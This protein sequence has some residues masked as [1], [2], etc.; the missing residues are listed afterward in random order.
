MV[1]S[2]TQDPYSIVVSLNLDSLRNLKIGHSLRLTE[3]LLEAC[4]LIYLCSDRT[5][6]RLERRNSEVTHMITVLQ[7]RTL[8]VNGRVSQHRTVSGKHIDT[9]TSIP[10]PRRSVGTHLPVLRRDIPDGAGEG[11]YSDSFYYS[12]A[13]GGGSQHGTV[14]GKHIDAE[15]SIPGPLRSAWTH[16]AVL[17]RD[18]PEAQKM[19]F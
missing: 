6:Q 14:S 4:G 18:I 7:V 12:A 1:S 13:S 5:S 8:S 11:I 16:L 10:G 9:Q 15:T 2:S 19:A 3:L 17:R